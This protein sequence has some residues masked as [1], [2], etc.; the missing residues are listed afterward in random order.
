MESGELYFR[1][2]W[3]N[4]KYLGL[5]SSKAKVWKEWLKGGTDLGKLTLGCL[6]DSGSLRTKLGAWG[7]VLCSSGIAGTGGYIPRLGARKMLRKHEQI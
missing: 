3:R 6:V 7:G 2:S 1:G 5:L 4:G